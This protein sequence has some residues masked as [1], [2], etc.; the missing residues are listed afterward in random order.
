MWTGVDGVSWAN[1][2][3]SCNDKLHHDKTPSLMLANGMWVGDVPLELS[4][5]TL[6]ERILVARYFPAAYI[7]E[8]VSG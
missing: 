1:V 5:L 7:V 4:V 3:T 8:G 6:P 2:C